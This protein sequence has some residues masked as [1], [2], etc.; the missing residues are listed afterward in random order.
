[1]AKKQ[2]AKKATAKTA[3][4]AKATAKANPK[5]GTKDS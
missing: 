5:V 2:D 4:T 1:M 3:K